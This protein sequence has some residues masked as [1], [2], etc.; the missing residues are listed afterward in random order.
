MQMVL[1]GLYFKTKV[2]WILFLSRTKISNHF[3][4]N[5]TFLYLR[6]MEFVGEFEI[7]KIM[8]FPN[9]TLGNSK[10]RN[11]FEYVVKRFEVWLTLQ[12]WL[13]DAKAALTICRF[14]MQKCILSTKMLNEVWK[15]NIRLREVQI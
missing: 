8:V 11:I 13:T 5:S 10:N 3:R 4:Q 12:Q 14:W 1:Q 7:F 6:N 9:I 15:I 2:F